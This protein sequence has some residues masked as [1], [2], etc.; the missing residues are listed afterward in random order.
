MTVLFKFFPSLVVDQRS[1]WRKPERKRSY[2]VRYAAGRRFGWIRQGQIARASCRSFWR[3][4]SRPRFLSGVDHE[5]Q[6]GDLILARLVSSPGLESISR[7]HNIRQND[8]RYGF[9]QQVRI[10]PRKVMRRQ[11]LT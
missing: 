3:W 4:W 11:R 6:V 9:D 1:L 7:D 10:K 5:R 2:L 8:H